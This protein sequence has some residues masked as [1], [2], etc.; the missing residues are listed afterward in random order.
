MATVEEIQAVIDALKAE[1]EPERD[2]S[3]GED[4]LE[5][6]IP[7]GKAAFTDFFNALTDPIGTAESVRDIGIGVYSLLTDGDRPEEAVALA[8]GEYYTDRYGSKEAFKNSVRTDPVGVLLDLA[9]FANPGLGG[10]KAAGT[11]AIRIADKIGAEKTADFLRKAGDSKLSE[12]ARRA[13]IASDIGSGAGAGRLAQKTPAFLG[14]AVATA[15]GTISGAGGDAVQRAFEIGREFKKPFGKRGQR[16]TD[17]MLDTGKLNV[18]PEQF[19][20][21]VDKAANAMRQ[22]IRDQYVAGIADIDMGGTN[23][24]GRTE[25]T[26]VTPRLNMS[27][28]IQRTV[29]VPTQ[30]NR[31]FFA[32]AF[33]RIADIKRQRDSAKGEGSEAEGFAAETSQA[34]DLMDNDIVEFSKSPL[35]DKEAAFKLRQK[36]DTYDF[37]PR[38]REDAFRNDLRGI[39][40]DEL[41]KDPK[42]KKVVEDFDE[43]TKLA[44]EIFAELS[45]GPTKNTSQKLRKLQSVT[46]NNVNTNFGRRVELL[47]RLN[48]DA[49]YD[50]LDVATAQ[51]LRQDQPTGAARI[52]QSG[53]QSLG[54][55]GVGSGV[56]E[57][58]SGIV[59]TLGQSMLTP[60][61]VGRAAYKTGQ[62]A[63]VLRPITTPT[64]MALPQAQNLGILAERSGAS[65]LGTGDEIEQNQ[66]LNRQLRE[67]ERYFRAN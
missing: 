61:N 28:D 6:I 2:N 10:A 51:A 41:K 34:I 26:S 32:N 37:P 18:S 62:V 52:G 56:V 59:A 31:P 64:A 23:V 9:S 27:P 45:L 8:L 21:D 44:D 50:L 43:A 35:P 16:F 38:S 48:P 15:S 39:L 14:R 67:L 33:S 24:F 11:G 4:V 29:T 36:L 5:N 54:V 53:S 60:Q 49:D 42:Y 20:A 17:T 57:P 30:F 22:Q 46:R 7:S 1:S 66:I 63:Q 58:S 13:L 47:N 12:A 25:T 65:S 19:A 55:L 3:F 40:S